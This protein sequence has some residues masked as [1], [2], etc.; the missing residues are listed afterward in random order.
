MPLPPPTSLM[1]MFHYS[2]VKR[3]AFTTALGLAMAATAKSQSTWNGGS[4]VNADWS[5]PQ[6]WVGGSAPTSSVATDIIFG[7][8]PIANSNVDSPFSLRTLIFNASAP[9][10]T[11]GGSQISI[12]GGAGA[13]SYGFSNNSS[14][15]QIVNNSLRLLGGTGF[16]ASAGSLTLNGPINLNGQNVRYR[17][18]SNQTLTLNGVIS[19]AG[20]NG[21]NSSVT[22][23]VVI[24][25]ANT[26]SAIQTNIWNGIVRVKVDSFVGASGAFGQSTSVVMGVQDTTASAVPTLL[27][28]AAVSIGQTIYLASPS[29][30]TAAYTIGGNSAHVSNYFGPIYT[31]EGARKANALTLTSAA[32]G[33]VN[34]ASVLQSATATTNTDNITVTGGGIVALTD[35]ST[36][37]G[38]TTVSTGTLL[39]NGTLSAT[40][41]NGSSVGAVTVNSGARLGGSGVINRSVNISNGGILSAGDINAA[42]LSQVGTLTLNSGL[43]LN[44][45]SILSFDLANSLSPS[46]LVAITGNLTLD[47]VINITALSGFGEGTYTLFSYTGT[48]V[49]NGLLLGTVPNTFTYS[50]D[51]TQAGLV[52]LMVVPEPQTLTLFACAGFL[53]ILLFRRKKGNSPSILV[54]DKRTI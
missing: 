43:T 13:D 47:G 46:D 23:A 31:V 44:N 19:G 3:I 16:Q 24:N 36:Y 26:W 7:S 45:N 8:S 14:A 39:V 2:A 48:L 49:D 21:F 40:S 15:A 34:I 6:N 42:G 29:T 41:G 25:A 52:R 11:L 54:A 4:G 53:A 22:G 5:T 32:N 17:A 35:L 51:T 18:T 9:A 12:Q 1:N 20:L 10:S 37:G 30:G 38:T 50:F 27:T 28:D 33:R